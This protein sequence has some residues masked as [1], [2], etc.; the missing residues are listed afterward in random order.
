MNIAK[1]MKDLQKMQGEL[2][3]QVDAREVEGT[4][5]GGFL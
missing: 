3:E 1:M 5:G 2:Q 4:A